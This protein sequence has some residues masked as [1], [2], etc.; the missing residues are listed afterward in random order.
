MNGKQLLLGWGLALALASGTEVFAQNSLVFPSATDSRVVLFGP[1]LWSEGDY[2]EGQRQ[3]D[4]AFSS[5]TM[6]LVLDMNYVQSCD[7]QD[8]AVLIDG[9]EVG[10]FS[11]LEFASEITQ[12]FNF[13]E[14]PAGVHTLRIQTLRTVT[15]GCGSAGFADDVSTLAWECPS[16]APGDLP[17]EEIPGES[18]ESESIPVLVDIDAGAHKSMLNLKS[19]GM[20]QVAILGTPEFDVSGLNPETFSILGVSPVQYQL[21]DAGSADIRATRDCGIHAQGRDQVPDLVLYFQTGSLAS[22]LEAAMAEAGETPRNGDC[23]NL[24]VNG[25]LLDGTPVTGE[26]GVVLKR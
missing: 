2:I 21:R 4:C 19:N 26:D 14:I 5:L 9:V 8:H 13:P 16:P 24:M 25:L 1:N 11:I 22:A 12:T 6:Q 23:V 3:F 18:G 7:T 15:G 17:A 20:L 10:R